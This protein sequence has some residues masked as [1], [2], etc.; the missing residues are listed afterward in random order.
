MAYQDASWH[1]EEGVGKVV[2]EEGTEE[3]CN[4]EEGPFGLGGG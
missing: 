2:E 1:G 3:D 4:E